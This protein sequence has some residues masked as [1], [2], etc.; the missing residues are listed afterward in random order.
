VT[1]KGRALD[2]IGFDVNNLQAFCKKPEA[3]GIK[4]DRPFE[5]CEW[6][7]HGLHL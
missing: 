3:S 1:T 7:R 6:H 5:E 4:L 2:H